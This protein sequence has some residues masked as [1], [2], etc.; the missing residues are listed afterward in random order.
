MSLGF[1]GPLTI[2][3]EIFANEEHFDYFSDDNVQVQR[4]KFDLE[5]VRPDWAKLIL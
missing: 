4:L 1:R 5:I 3:G 2:D